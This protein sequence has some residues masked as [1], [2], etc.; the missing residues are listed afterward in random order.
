MENERLT[1]G[2]RKS[3]TGIRS[4]ALGGCISPA[5]A[6]KSATPKMGNGGDLKTAAQQ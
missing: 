6:R 1:A 5:S 4:P 3:R 2:H